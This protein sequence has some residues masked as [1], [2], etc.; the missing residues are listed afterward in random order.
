MDKQTLVS[1][2]RLEE[3]NLCLRTLWAATS[4]VIKPCADIVGVDRTKNGSVPTSTIP[5]IAN[6]MTVTA[7]KLARL[8]RSS[9]WLICIHGSGKVVTNGLSVPPTPNLKIMLSTEVDM[10]LRAVSESDTVDEAPAIWRPGSTKSN[11]LK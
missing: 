4:V 6:E 3:I 8:F 10:Y 1:K 2:G 9:N 5:G 11:Q 7:G